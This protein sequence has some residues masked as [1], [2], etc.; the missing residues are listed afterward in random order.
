MGNHVFYFEV[1]FFSA[2]SKFCRS[3]EEDVA[4]AVECGFAGVLQYA[5]DEADAD[6]LHSDIIAD[7]ERCAG[8]GNQEQRAAGNAGCTAGT[9]RSDDGQQE[10]SRNIDVDAERMSCC[11]GQYG[12]G[13]SCAGHVDRRAER[14]GDGVNIRVEAQAFAQAHVYRDIGSGA[15]GEECVDA[16]FTQCSEDERIG[17]AARMEKYDQ[18][19]HHEGYEEEGAEQYAQQLEVAE[20]CAEAAGADGVGDEAHDAERG[21]ADYPLYDLRNGSGKVSDSFFRAVRGMM[22][23]DADEDGPSENADVVGIDESV[24]RVVDDADEQV[25]KYF[26]DAAG[27]CDLGISY[28]QVKHGREE[29]GHYNA[30]ERSEESAEYVQAYDRFHRSVAVVF[31][32]C[33]SVDYEHKYE[34]RCDAF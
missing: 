8:N 6:Y 19:I 16:A 21:E 27:R 17:I 33:H 5:D 20:Q 25:V 26:Y 15:A 13:D 7:A 18:R 31:F 1:A 4:G 2:G 11:Q 3:G 34:D 32:L 30:D 9:D 10:S 14:N 24:Y 29:E 28:L 12:D 22:E 23:R